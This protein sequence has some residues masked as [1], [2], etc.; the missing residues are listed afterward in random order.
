MLA[1][2]S[3]LCVVSGRLHE[4]FPMKKDY[5]LPAA[6]ALCAHAFLFLGFSPPERSSN[7][8]L[9]QPLPV[10]PKKEPYEVVI[11]KRETSSDQT[12]GQSVIRSEPYLPPDDDHAKPRGDIAV[13]PVTPPTDPTLLPHLPFKP[14]HPDLPPG[15][16]L[17]VGSPIFGKDYL[18]APPHAL[19]QNAPDYPYEARKTGQEGR[20]LVEFVVNPRGEVIQSRI[21]ESSHPVFDQS[22][23]RAV[24]HWRFQPGTKNGVPVTFRMVVP[25][26]FA[27]V[28]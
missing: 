22:T 15:D 2:R 8:P 5:V 25:V 13:P 28:D 4:L 26:N 24:S 16:L 7:P 6:V 10:E 11:E 3:P 9:A 21:V 23:L 17:E 12:G 20:V 1:P 27:P 18:D 19:V 14:G